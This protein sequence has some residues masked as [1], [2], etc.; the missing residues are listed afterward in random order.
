MFINNIFLIEKKQKN[1]KREKRGRKMSKKI[2]KII[3]MSM[4]L[5]M[6]LRV[7]SLANEDD[8]QV[9]QGDFAS[10]N[11]VDTYTVC[12]DFRKMDAAAVCL[13]R[14][15]YVGANVKVYDEDGK[16]LMKITTFDR[17]AKNWAY[18]EKPSS[19]A[20]ICNY[21]IQVTP[22]GYKDSD[23][24]YRII[25]GDKQETELMMSGIE[26][27]VLLEQYYESKVNL[28]N[29]YYVPNLG[30][31]WYKYKEYPTNIITVLSDDDNLRFKV[32]DADTLKEQYSSI[33]HTDSHKKKFLGSSGALTS[34]EKANVTLQ[35]GK[36]YYLVV[37]SINP[38]KGVAIK[39][40]C[41]ATAVGNPVM[42]YSSVTI[43]PGK[44]LTAVSSRFTTTSFNI[45]GNNIPDTAQV[46]EVYFGGTRNSNI[47]SWE[48][49]GPNQTSWKISSSMAVDMGFIKD[50]SKNVKVKG[51]WRT[52]FKANSVVKKITFVPTYTIYYAY[53]YGD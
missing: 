28:Q 53:E 14:K 50:S 20:T 33:E 42:A 22:N 18:I 34:A 9:F 5:C 19:D 48:A 25:V 13:V 4:C 3:M 38:I 32:L 8:Y 6:F 39:D 52:G 1:N 16:Q 12:V 51:T 45:T 35:Q 49:M 41:M 21:T 17:K 2:I 26:N 47:Y 11:E 24:S 29:N 30:E 7:T 40:G 43:K 27:T 31:Y 10:A 37:Y 44:G 15:G 36:E 46:T 23:S